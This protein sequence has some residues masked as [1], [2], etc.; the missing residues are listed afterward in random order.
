LIENLVQQIS[1]AAATNE[2][3]FANLVFDVFNALKTFEMESN[4]EIFAQIAVKLFGFKV[5]RISVRSDADDD[6]IK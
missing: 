3:A 1:C 4:D 5:C 6:E 2:R